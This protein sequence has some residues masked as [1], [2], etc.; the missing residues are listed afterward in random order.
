MAS[1]MAGMVVSST[2]PG[3]GSVNDGG[4]MMLIEAHTTGTVL[5]DGRRARADRGRIAVIDAVVGLFEEGSVGATTDVIAQ[6]AGV[7][8][9]SVF[10]YYGDV[11]GVLDEALAVYRDRLG[12]WTSPTPPPAASPTGHRVATIAAHHTRLGFVTGPYRHA[13]AAVTS[14]YVIPGALER[15]GEWSRLCAVHTGDW[16]A[17]EL[18]RYSDPARSV[19][20]VAVAAVVDP[21][22]L[23]VLRHHHG[24]TAERLEMVLTFELTRLLHHN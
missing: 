21:A 6:R 2:G 12:S 20:A 8:L 3:S 4:T 18:D 10:R 7:S 16:F 15:T 5:V 19:V 22:H 23:D 17:A 14:R 13:L 9:R 1:W 11:P 24:L